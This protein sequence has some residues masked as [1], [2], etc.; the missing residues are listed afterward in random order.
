MANVQKLESAGARIALA[1]DTS[2]A[3]MFETMRCAISVA[4][5]QGGGYAVSARSAIR[6]AFQNAAAA[7]RST[8]QIGSIE[9]GKKADLTFLDRNAPNLAPLIEGVG[10]LV[11]SANSGNVTDVMVGGRFVLKDRLPTLFDGDEVIAQAQSTAERLWA[12]ARNGV[13]Q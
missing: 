3:D 9:V 11:W 7:L 12:R 10:M 6:W 1:T 2:S 5:V 13:R 4:R 8:D